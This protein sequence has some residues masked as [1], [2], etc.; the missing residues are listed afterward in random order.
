MDLLYS[1]TDKIMDTLHDELGFFLNSESNRILYSG[2]PNYK[3]DDEIIKACEERGFKWY[4]QGYNY[5]EDIRDICF[6]PPSRVK[7]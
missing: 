1:N 4:A 2:K 5:E 3:V 6:D 7:L